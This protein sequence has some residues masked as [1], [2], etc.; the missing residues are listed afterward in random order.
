MFNINSKI[1]RR[2]MATIL[3]FVAIFVMIPAIFNSYGDNAVINSRVVSVHSPIEGVV[4]N[5]NL[6]PGDKVRDNQSVMFL[7][8]LRINESFVHELE[9]ERNSLQSRVDGYN[10]HLN[11]LINLKNS[12]QQR[13][14]QTKKFVSSHVDLELAK[15][16]Q[17][18]LAQE[19]V[20]AERALYAQ[21]VIPLEASGAMA[22]HEVDAARYSLIENENKLNALKLR[23]KEL[24]TEKS[25]VS[26]NVN[27][28]EGR[29]DVP[30]SRQKLDEVIVIISDYKT[31]LFEQETR[32]AEIDKQIAIE[33]KRLTMAKNADILS[34]LDGIIWKQYVSNGSEVV[35]GTELIQ[36]VDCKNLFI[37]VG[38]SENSLQG[39]D[40]GSTV[41]YRLIGSNDWKEGTVYQK[42][43]T[44]NKKQDVTLAALL[45]AGKSES[46]RI[47]IK[48]N[49]EDVKASENN[50]C[51]IGRKVEVS[52]PRTYNLFS[53]IN[54]LTSLL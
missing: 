1:S 32:I 31:R 16:K 19:A 42:T 41:K 11:E 46:A 23:V 35:I 49:P 34:P 53:W 7:T 22:K 10:K 18:M 52:I 15:A 4:K 39:L 33:R 9:V 40:I 28:G 2:T 25:A 12:L 29:N 47:F 30:Y 45:D 48:F 44:A 43:G 27:I 13:T 17:Q 21:R 3:F 14:G 38:V 5:F 36:I 20:V 37:E 50:F 54:R 24:E 26:N 6:K 51:N 8:N